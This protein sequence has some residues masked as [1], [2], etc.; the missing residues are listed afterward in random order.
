MRP[1]VRR[2]RHFPGVTATVGTRSRTPI[3]LEYLFSE[4]LKN[5]CS[6]VFFLF[7]KRVWIVLASPFQDSCK[8]R[9]SQRRWWATASISWRRWRS[10]R[11][12]IGRI[13]P[14]QFVFGAATASYQVRR[15][16]AFSLLIVFFFRSV[17]WDCVTSSVFCRIFTA[18]YQVR[19]CSCFCKIR[20]CFLCFLCCRA[21]DS[22]LENV[23]MSSVF[24]CGLRWKVLQM[25]E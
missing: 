22:V 17:S 24:G 3:A 6:Y 12:Y 8:K 15:C 21:W 18:S 9:L 5:F 19:G 10:R 7:E 11:R 1:L 4:F 25:G 14:D 20:R 2:L 23:V 16:S 13:F